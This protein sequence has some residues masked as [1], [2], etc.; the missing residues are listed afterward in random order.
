MV[1]RAN[2]KS[3]SC[4][5]EIK[6]NQVSNQKYNYGRVLVSLHE[7]G[8]VELLCQMANGRKKKLK[9]KEKPCL[10]WQEALLWQS[11]LVGNSLRYPLWV[12]TVWEKDKRGVGG[13]PLM[14]LYIGQQNRKENKLQRTVI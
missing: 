5:G 14:V 2:S 3:A 11:L 9:Q 7:M 1:R 6:K 10:M 8:D 4:L 13:G 12:V